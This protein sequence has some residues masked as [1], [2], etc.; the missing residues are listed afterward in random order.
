MGK[1]WAYTKIRTIP[2]NDPNIVILMILMIFIF[3]SFFLR[4]RSN[5]NFYPYLVILSEV[6]PFN[7]IYFLI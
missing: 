4:L 1:E 5:I 3:L 6:S 2:G 7:T